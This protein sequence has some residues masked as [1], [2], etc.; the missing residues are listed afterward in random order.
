M[1]ERSSI[2]MLASFGTQKRPVTITKSDG[3]DTIQRNIYSTF[4]MTPDESQKPYQIQFYDAE[5]QTHIDLCSATSSRFL[6]IRQKLLTQSLLP[7]NNP[8]G[9]LKLVEKTVIITQVYNAQNSGIA[10]IVQGAPVVDLDE[11]PL[12]QGQDDLEM[13]DI[14]ANTS[15]LLELNEGFLESHNLLRMGGSNVSDTSLSLLGKF[16]FSYA[17]VRRSMPLYLDTDNFERPSLQS[18]SDNDDGKYFAI[19]IDFFSFSIKFQM[20]QKEKH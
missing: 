3:L 16:Y 9:H 5:F 1:V 10:N 11:Y 6:T 2:S 20:L 19:H 4:E 12:G 15:P 18:A 7:K 8:E 14:V 13:D 17:I